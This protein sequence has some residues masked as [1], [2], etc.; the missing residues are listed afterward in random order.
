M[1]AVVTVFANTGVKA[2]ASRR[3]GEVAFPADALSIMINVSF[4][5]RLLAGN[6][7]K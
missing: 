1:P 4:P 2:R 5:G 6:V 7:V 3:A